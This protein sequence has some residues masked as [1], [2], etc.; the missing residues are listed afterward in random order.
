M[1]SSFLLCFLPI[2]LFSQEPQNFLAEDPDFQEFRIGIRTSFDRQF[3][4]PYTWKA[5]KI[6]SLLH[7][8]NMADLIFDWQPF[9]RVSF[10]RSQ[11]GIGYYQHRNTS[12]AIDSWK[13][14]SGL[15]V[16][17]RDITDISYFQCAL[18]LILEP[19]G[20][21][22]VSPYVNAQ[23]LLALPT[24]LNYEFHL[25]SPTSQSF[26]LIQ[27]ISGGGKNSPGWGINSG[28]RVRLFKHW[29]F[30]VGF[31]YSEQDFLID[32]PI[33]P[34]R[35]FGDTILRQS[36]SGISFQWQYRW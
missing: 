27:A 17:F 6:V 34:V 35:D 21:S 28:L 33:V 36:N 22:R 19:F 30:A 31:H 16:D 7:R 20:R 8:K 13:A 25:Q 18:G 2:F 29:L 1:R 4:D 15:N 24:E 5:N 32:W 23:F 10:L 3:Y 26:P 14:S 12:V 11:L 9:S